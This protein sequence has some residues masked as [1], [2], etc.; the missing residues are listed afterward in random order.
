MLGTISE[1]KLN[2]TATLKEGKEY[3]VID[4]RKTINDLVAN[5]KE[6]VQARVYKNLPTKIS[7]C[8]LLVSNYHRSSSPIVEAEAIEDLIKSGETY[9]SISA[10]TG[11]SPAQLQQKVSLLKRLPKEIADKLRSREI[12]ESTAKKIA[13]LPK[14][15]QSK[16]VKEEKITGDV[17]ERYHKEYLNKQFSMDEMEFPKKVKGTAT[18]LF[19]MVT[20]GNK[21]KK[22]NRKELF[23]YLE[24]LL[25]IITVGGELIII[26]RHK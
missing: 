8:V 14:D 20:Y 16:L 13:S 12:P 4:G 2:K 17:V 10:I 7:K 1:V 26:Q 6:T 9:K 19:Y 15:V 18:P 11:I 24:D 23:S 21:E 3:L 5:G 25:P 22:V